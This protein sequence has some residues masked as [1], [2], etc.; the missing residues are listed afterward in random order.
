MLISLQNECGT[1]SLAKEYDGFQLEGELC[2]SYCLKKQVV[3]FIWAVCR[4]IIPQDLLGTTSNW[5]ILRKHISRFV[6]LRRF[7][8]FSLKQCMHKLKISGFPL[9]SNKHSSCNSGNHV[10]RQAKGQ[11]ANTYDG[12]S[13]ISFSSDTMKHKVLESWIFWFFSS[14]VV[15]LV[16]ANFYVTESE[17]GKQEVFYYR[18]SIWEKLMSRAITCLKNQ[19]Y[20]LLDGESL[21]KIIGKRSFGFSRVRF[22]P[23]ENGVRAL[24]NLKASSRIPAK[25]PS[26]RVQSCGLQ[27]KVSLH[28][29]S[30][31][32]DNFRSVNGVLRD[33]HVV[34][35]GI[36]LKEPEKLGSSVFD[37]NDVFRK[38]HPFL[39]VLKSRS[40]TM[41]GV[42][43][44][45]SDVSKAF[46]SINQDKL[47]TVMKD[48]ALKDGYLLKKSH[49]VVCAE[50][51][52]WVHQNLILGHQDIST[53]LS[54]LT[55][56]IPAHSRHSI[57]VDQEWSRTI[58]KEEIHFYLREH[59]KGN[60]LQ[61]DKKFYLQSVGIPQGSVLSSL[62][63]S[64]YYGHLDKN[65]IFPFLEKSC[66][67]AAAEDLSGRPNR[68]DCFSAL[69]S[70]EDEIMSSAPKYMLLRFI[71]DLLFIS[72]SK[73]QAASFFSRLQR[74]FREYNCYMNQE[75]FG[76][77]FDIE[78]ISGDTRKRVYVVED[79]NSFLRWSGLFINCC[80][81]EVQ[82][83]Y[84]RFPSLF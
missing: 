78:Q 56:A 63:C 1:V 7:E 60:V 34:L 9:L 82:A 51:S 5:R 71:D 79:G 8:R 76:L 11:S 61:V 37:Y 84:T 83:D 50:K 74:G 45:V 27:G 75:K 42:F 6:H 31:K 26:F 52:L 73:K 14:L 48:V 16:Q 35:K 67:S 40:G 17:H 41:P 66:G 38:L 43:I 44:V 77:N 12:W 58:R 25:Q 33:L 3:S 80:T 32:Y 57:L 36:Q 49:Q 53:G 54:N 55:S 4:S 70:G 81:L 29:K 10:M 46:D 65:V 62:L 2:K 28:P 15:P 21:R 18:K 68:H 20:C 69:D 72:T 13:S 59:V 23:K 39:S 47:L 24:A 64:L 30:V 19:S 22:R